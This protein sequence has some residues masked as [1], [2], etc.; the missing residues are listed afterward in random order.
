MMRLQSGSCDSLF[1]KTDI[2]FTAS[3]SG[4][5]LSDTGNYANSLDDDD[6]NAKIFNGNTRQTQPQVPPLILACIDHLLKYGL[7]VVGIFR[8]STSKR[9][10]REVKFFKISTQHNAMIINLYTVLLTLLTHTS[11]VKNWIADH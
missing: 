8:V 1:S 9:R 5:S 7:N 10:I 6:P 4:D 3:N 2:R 11:Y